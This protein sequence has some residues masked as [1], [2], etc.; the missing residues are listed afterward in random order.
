[1]LLDDLH[2]AEDDLLDLL[3]RV[4]GRPA[5]RCCSSARLDRSSSSGG[6]A[7]G[8]AAERSGDLA[9]AA[10]RRRVAPPAPRVA[11]GRAAPRAAR[12][13]RSANRRQPVLRRGARP[14]P[15]RRRGGR[16]VRGRL[17]AVR[18]V[19]RSWSSPTPCRQ[20]SQPAS[21]CC[22]PVRRRAPGGGRDRARLLA[23][24]ARA[25]GRR[26]RAWIWGCSRSV[27]SSGG[28]QAP[29]SVT[30]MS[31]RSSTPSRARSRTPASRRRGAPV[32]TPRWRAGSRATCRAWT[33]RRRLGAPLCGGRET[34]GRGP[35]LAGRPGELDSPTG[36]SPPLART[37]GRARAGPV[38]DLG[39]GRALRARSS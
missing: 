8:G 20:F 18:R 5:G 17:E 12:S 3:E 13:H 19:T 4:H 35:C 16:A 37:C 14:E 34:R 26:R 28:T 31:T 33:R 39:G 24:S 1:M 25:P 30:T 38:R 11:A 15:D 32:S 29:R 9:R 10:R 22:R 21:T 6:R 27:T 2:W 36:A 23:R 7:G